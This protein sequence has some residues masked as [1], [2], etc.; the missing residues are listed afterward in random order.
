MNP[1]D[2]NTRIQNEVCYDSIH[3]ISDETLMQVYANSKSVKREIDKLK[4]ILHKHIETQ[5]TAECI[6]SEYLLELIPAGTKGVIR[7]NTFNKMVEKKI[8]ELSLDPH[9]WEVC[10]E[11]QCPTHPTSEIPDWYIRHRHTN[12]I[13][14]GMN[15]L[16]FWSGG[17]QSNRGA[18]YINSE[19]NTENSKLLC[20]VCNYIQFTRTQGKTYKL[21]ET[22]FKN[23]TIC[24]L[25]NLHNIINTFINAH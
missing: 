15:Q 25:N 22:G 19:H 14:I 21:F 13:L 18:K 3:A 9:K 4:T 17:Q 12:R 7:G 5:A 16:D 8:L 10:F 1:T 20:V 23:D 24:Y 2:I 11:S 6:L